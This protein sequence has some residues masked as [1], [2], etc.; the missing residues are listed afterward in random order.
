MSA[1]SRT[2]GFEN[3]DRLRKQFGDFAS[4][5]RFGE[6]EHL[7]ELQIIARVFAANQPLQRQ[8]H[9]FDVDVLPVVTH[10]A[11]HVHQHGGGTFRVVAG[12]MNDDIFALHPQRQFRRRRESWH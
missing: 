3:R 2:Y 8:T 9:A 4:R 1:Q 5:S 11:A 10:R 12:T 7:D 6:R